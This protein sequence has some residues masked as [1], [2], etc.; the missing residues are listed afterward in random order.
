MNQVGRASGRNWRWTWP[1]RSLAPPTWNSL[2]SWALRRAEAMPGGLRT[3]CQVGAGIADDH[4]SATVIS[5][6]MSGDFAA[7]IAAGATHVRLGSA[8]LGERAGF[9]VMSEAGGGFPTRSVQC[10]S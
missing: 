10:T 1:I 7:A 9:V 3:A 8:L 4:N 6:G 2:G 5:A